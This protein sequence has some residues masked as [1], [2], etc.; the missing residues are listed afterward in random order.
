[1]AD[2]GSGQGRSDFETRGVVALRRGLQN[3]ENAGLGQE[4][5]FQY[6][7]SMFKTSLTRKHHGGAGLVAGFY[8][9]MVVLGA[10]GLN[11]GAYSLLQAYVDPVPERKERIADHSCADHAAFFRSH[12][13]VDFGFFIQVF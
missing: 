3:S 8:H 4:M 1:M 10:A 12:A 6:R 5:L 9:Q 13:G 2:F 7:H 11:H